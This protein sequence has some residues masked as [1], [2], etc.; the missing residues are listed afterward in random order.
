MSTCWSVAAAGGD[1]VIRVDENGDRL[2]VS[3]G[4]FLAPPVVRLSLVPNEP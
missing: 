1:G 4:P 2:M 3:P